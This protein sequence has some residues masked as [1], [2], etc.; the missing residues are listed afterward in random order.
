M[1]FTRAKRKAFE[2]FLELEE[3][4]KNADVVY[5]VE[6]SLL[7]IHFQKIVLRGDE[8]PF[9]VHATEWGDGEAE[10]L[11]AAMKKELADVG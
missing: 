2:L 8:K 4:N 3:E 1:N 9:S 5:H 6:F 11:I 7:S 10:A